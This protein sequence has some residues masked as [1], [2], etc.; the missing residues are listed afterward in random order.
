MPVDDGGC[1]TEE[2]RDYAGL[3]PGGQQA[4]RR[5]PAR[6]GPALARRDENQRVVL[7]VRASYAPYPHWL[8]LP[9]AAHLQGRFLLV[10]AVSAIRDRMVELNQD[11]DW[12]PR[13]HQGRQLRQVAGESRAIASGALIPVWVS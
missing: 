7:R 4:H 8:A 2:I 13:P 5:R 3:R 10:R 9:Q 6:R 1:L 12:Y 11:I